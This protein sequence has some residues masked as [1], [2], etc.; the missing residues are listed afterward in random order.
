MTSKPLAAFA[1]RL[2][3]PALKRL[4]DDLGRRIA[5]ELFDVVFT[6]AFEEA[7]ERRTQ[8][9]ILKLVGVKA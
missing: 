1:H 3:A 6:E 5:L 2:R 4:L 7:L 9:A 8:Q